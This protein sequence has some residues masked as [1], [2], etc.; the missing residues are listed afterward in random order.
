[1]TVTVNNK[2]PLVVPLAVRRKAGLR[3][4]DKIEFKVAA[5]GVI[6]IVPKPPDDPFSIEKITELLEEAKK[7]L[8]TPREFAAMDREI[9]AYGARQAKKTGIKEEDV[10][11]IVR[12]F[13]ARNRGT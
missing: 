1:M 10:P 8:M 3:S 13:R 9:K 5:G 2:K 6:H 12:E 7:N 11:R 4:G